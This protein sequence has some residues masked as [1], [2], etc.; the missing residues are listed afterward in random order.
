MGLDFYWGCLISFFCKG[1]NKLHFMGGVL[2]SGTYSHKFDNDSL[3][4]IATSFMLYTL[5]S[6]FLLPL[7]TLLNWST[8]PFWSTKA[9]PR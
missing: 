6:H 8:S 4:G 5:L 1:E 7:T 2:S 3:K 9:A